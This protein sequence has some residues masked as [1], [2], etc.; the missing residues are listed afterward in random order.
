MIWCPYTDEELHPEEA[1]REHIIPLS[2]GGM[3]GFEIPVDKEFNSKVG[4]KLDGTLA[5]DFL[6]AM[7]RNAHDVRGHSKRRPVVVAKKST[8]ADT[9]SPLQVTFDRTN[10][11]KIWCPI[12][13]EYVEAPGKKLNS[14]FRLDMDIDIRF[15]AKVALSA[16]YFAYG[17]NFRRDVKHSE[18]RLIMNNPLRDLGDEI[19]SIETLA[20]GRFS[21]D[22][23]DQL[24]IFRALCKAVAPAS[25]VG[26][27][28][29][30]RNFGVF[31]GILGSYMGMV[32]VP[33]TTDDFP[34][35][36]A[37]DLGHVICPQN[38]ELV[39]VSFRRALQKL[40]GDV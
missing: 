37:Y 5:N 10:G 39:R 36:D 30:P 4:A 7:S 26:L 24:R 6:V 33:A 32:N 21:S 13:K 29:R 11:L 31:V 23:T 15:V 16:G 19:Y 20:D 22:N 1:S 25:I 28:L 35:E 12:S 40:V 3:D 34:Y 8:D 2:L 18:L 14:Q 38:G 9:E 27:V 17:E